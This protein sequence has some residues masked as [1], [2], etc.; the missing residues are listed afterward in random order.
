M[1]EPLTTSTFVASIVIG[2][3]VIL[4]GTLFFV[5]RRGLRDLTV[6]WEKRAL[7]DNAGNRLGR[8]QTPFWNGFAGIGAIVLGV[9]MIASGISGLVF[10]GS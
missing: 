1:G 2:A 9:V 3:V 5:F 4:L 8:L 7:G 10:A 6:R